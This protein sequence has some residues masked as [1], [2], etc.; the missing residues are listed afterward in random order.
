MPTSKNLAEQFPKEKLNALLSTFWDT[1]IQSPLKK[2]SP[3]QA[4]NTVFALQPELSSQQAVGIL[5]SCVT[6]LGH[7]PSVN[8]IEK[9]GYVNKVAFVS[10]LLA[11]IA[12]EYSE[13]QGSALTSII[14]VKGTQNATATV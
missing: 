11:K 10:G 3:I 7:R 8:V 14:N 1:K 4:A 13:R 6:L 9:G 5:V 12:S 2:P